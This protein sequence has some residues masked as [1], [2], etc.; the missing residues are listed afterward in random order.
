M[1]SVVDRGMLLTLRHR[2][3]DEVGIFFPDDRLPDL[4]HLIQRFALR[5]EEASIP[6]LVQRL[7]ETGSREAIWQAFI[8]VITVG[9]TYFMRE[10]KALKLLEEEVLLPLI[11]RQ[12]QGA[13]RI[14]LWSAGCCTGEETYTLAILL[15][16]LLP[17]PA[18]W[19]IRI[20]GTDLNPG[21]LET[22]RQG[23]YGSWSFR[24]VD[25]AIRERFFRFDG[26]AWEVRAKLKAWVHFYPLNL[27]GGVYR[28][29]VPELH[30]LDA[31]LCRNV[32]MYFRPEDIGRV[33]A[34]LHE[35]LSPGGWLVVGASE[36]SHVHFNAF[37]TCCFPQAIFYRKPMAPASKRDI[38]EMAVPVDGGIKPRKPWTR[39]RSRSARPVSASVQTPAVPESV[40]ELPVAPP[41]SGPL[42]PC[43]QS[44]PTDRLNPQH[45]RHQASLLEEGDR[46]GE[47]VSAWRTV[48]YLEPHDAMAH[49]QLANLYRRQGQ[50]QDAQRHYRN[51]LGLLETGGE[52]MQDEKVGA[53]ELICWIKEMLDGGLDA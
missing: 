2:I 24:Q 32:L 36:A 12:R 46:L 9:E 33:T 41:H 38:P 25:P 40:E 22:A 31:I 43:C 45:Y 44:L 48:L 16:R 1:T 39:F 10:P 29:Q 5:M 20:I 19:D 50:E 52:V 30:D 35:A 8:D 23:R 21:F 17:D 3:V 11:T 15:S 6:P 37:E 47:A 49:F 14:R 28:N 34:R 51:A 26:K 13:R 7:L 4:G 18:A 27:M 42:R 53:G